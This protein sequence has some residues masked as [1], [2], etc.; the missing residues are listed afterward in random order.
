MTPPVQPP[1][2][3]LVCTN[4]GDETHWL[5]A[6]GLC[7]Y[8]ETQAERDDPTA[9][10]AAASTSLDQPGTGAG[11]TAVEPAQPAG[12]VLGD[13]VVKRAALAL[14][15]VQHPR[16]SAKTDASPVGRIITAA[17]NRRA[18]AAVIAALDLPALLS[19]AR[20]EGAG[21]RAK[22]EEQLAATRMVEDMRMAEI[23]RLTDELRSAREDGA[24]AERERIVAELRG[25]GVEGARCAVLVARRQP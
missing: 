22:Y 3:A 5:S 4:C 10:E 25:Y 6:R 13:D 7:D 12:P 19:S 21:W 18:V 17:V 16:N 8:C 9:A 2:E 24:T 23:G 15:R 1:T 11:Y 14:H 20:E